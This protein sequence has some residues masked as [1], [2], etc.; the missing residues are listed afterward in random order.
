MRSIESENEDVPYWRKL[1]N[2]IIEEN[3]ATIAAGTWT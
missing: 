2:N 3:I 1:K